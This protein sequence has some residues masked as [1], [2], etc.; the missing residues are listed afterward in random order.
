MRIRTAFRI[1]DG[2]EPFVRYKPSIRAI[3]LDNH[4]NLLLNEGL[5]I[6]C[7]D[8][9]EQSAGNYPP[10]RTGKDGKSYLITTTVTLTRD[11]FIKFGQTHNIWLLEVVDGCYFS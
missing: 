8:C 2:E 7:S 10:T 9:E 3:S 11:D 5:I 4:N 6:S 1:K